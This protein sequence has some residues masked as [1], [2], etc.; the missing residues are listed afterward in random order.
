MLTSIPKE[1][2]LKISSY[3]SIPDL[4]SLSKVCKIIA[5]LRLYRLCISNIACN[6]F[7]GTTS[8]KELQNELYECSSYYNYKEDEYIHE[9][10]RDLYS[11]LFD[12]Y[13]LTHSKDYIHFKPR[14]F[15]IQYSHSI[16]FIKIMHNEYKLTKNSINNNNKIKMF[17]RCHK[18]YRVCLTAYYNLRKYHFNVLALIY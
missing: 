18:T 4:C 13:L 16:E 2:I 12:D 7:C 10:I 6:R 14:Y 1:L 17:K 8:Y 5:E 11:I 9:Y 3:C 15:T